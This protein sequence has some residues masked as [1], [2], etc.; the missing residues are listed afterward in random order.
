MLAA[1]A[2]AADAAA[3]AAVVAAVAGAEIVVAPFV[4]TAVAIGSAEIGHQQPVAVHHQ[5]PDG[6]VA[7]CWPKLDFVEQQM[8]MGFLLA[9]CWNSPAI[10]HWWELWRQIP[11]AAVA[12]AA[13]ETVALIVGIPPPPPSSG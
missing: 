3:D 5:L 12:A 10:A 1:A 4:P 8:L 13:V 7:N 6:M 11:V 9:A 2:A